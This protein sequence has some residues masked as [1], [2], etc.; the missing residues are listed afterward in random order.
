MKIKKKKKKINKFHI[1]LHPHAF[2]YITTLN[3]G[4]FL[5]YGVFNNIS[6]LI[7]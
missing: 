2:S 6:I 4:V 1:L 3:C 7:Y 5:L